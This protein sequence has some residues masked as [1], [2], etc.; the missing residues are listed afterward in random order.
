MKRIIVFGSMG[1]A[2]DCLRWLLRQSGV[3]VLGVVCSTEPL[4]KWRLVQKDENM[5]DEAMRLGVPVLKLE[6]VCELEADLGISVRYHELLRARHLERF[7]LGVVNLHGAPLPEMRGSMCDA[8]AIIEGREEYGTSIHWMNEKVDEGLLIGVKRF[9]IKP[10]DTVYELF[11]LSNQY[12]L[13]LLKEWLPRIWEGR[14]TGVDQLALAEELQIEPRTYRAQEVRML[15]QIPE[16]AAPQFIYNTARA[17][18]FPGHEPAYMQT[19]HGKVYV[20]I[21][22]D[23]T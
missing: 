21:A 2:V 12:G 22:S 7:T 4:S 9:P 14:V 18:Q 16:H 8:A 6:Q 23:N 20:S 17:F 10:A 13:E 1:V 11:Q 5:Y 15:K 19:D 3:E